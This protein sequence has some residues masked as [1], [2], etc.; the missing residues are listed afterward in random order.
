MATGN[1][2]KIVFAWHE[3]VVPG[4]RL[5]FR[6]L[7]ALGHEVTVIAP[8]GW[9]VDGNDEH[10]YTVEAD[11]YRLLG[12]PVAYR[13]R[14]EK[15]FYM[16]IIALALTLRMA[17]PDIV[18]VFEAPYSASAFQ[19]SLLARLVSSRAK[20]VVETG[21]D[22]QMPVGSSYEFFNRHVIGRCALF[23]SATGNDGEGARRRERFLMPVAQAHGA[24]E[25]EA[26]SVEPW[27]SA[28]TALVR[29][30]EGL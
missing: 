22:T 26:A 28:A 3:A 18:H 13:N 2:L 17:R 14:P 20:L 8:E 25:G 10:A 30:Y 1:K 19:I 29:L 11:G 23:L 27:Q 4:R 16:D 6:E 21:D 9:R 15:F 24:D 7:A 5:L 12:L